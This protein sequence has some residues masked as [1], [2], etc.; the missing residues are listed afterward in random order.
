MS[1]DRSYH[2]LVLPKSCTYI[3][4]VGYQFYTIQTKIYRLFLDDLH[5]QSD[6]LENE[7]L[8]QIFY[9]LLVICEI[10]CLFVWAGVSPYDTLLIC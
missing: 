5:V 3:V 8:S 9:Y 2:Y 4:T 6:Q 10:G 7:L 1:V